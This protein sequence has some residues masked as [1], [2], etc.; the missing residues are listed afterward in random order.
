MVP[1]DR[2]ELLVRKRGSADRTSGVTLM[3]D[4]QLLRIA[5]APTLYEI[6]HGEIVESEYI[7]R[8]R[9]Q[10]ELILEHALI[11]RRPGSVECIECYAISHLAEEAL[12]WTTTNS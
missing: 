12:R 6:K 7:K 2:A 5:A 8:I 11:G 10:L 4:D 9:R 1:N 3:D